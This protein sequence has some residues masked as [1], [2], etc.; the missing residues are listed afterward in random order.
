MSDEEIQKHSA[1]LIE[2]FGDSLPDI[3][4]EPVRFA[5]YVKMY[6]YFNQT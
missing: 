6:R 1:G 2:M 5:F 4:H 3:D